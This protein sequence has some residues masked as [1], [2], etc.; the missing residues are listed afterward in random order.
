MIK[1]E[2]LTASPGTPQDL[3]Q[4]VQA[5]EQRWGHVVKEDHIKPE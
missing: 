5:Q 2:G 3:A 4:Y 1:R